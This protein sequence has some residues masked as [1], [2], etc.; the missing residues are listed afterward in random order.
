MTSIAEKADYVRARARTDPG[1]HHCH[2]TG[3]TKK[4]PPSK[5]GCFEHWRRLPQSLR[6][7]IWATFRPGQEETKTPSREYVAV[8]LEVREWIQHD[9]DRTRRLSWKYDL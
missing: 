6:N 7:K 5:W 9:I 8:A 3:C 2:W 4:V 1:S